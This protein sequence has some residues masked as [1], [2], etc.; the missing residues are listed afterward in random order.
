VFRRWFGP[1]SSK[2]EK[3]LLQRCFGDTG[4]VERLI[5]YEMARRPQLSR[6]GASK[7]ALDRWARDR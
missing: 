6:D 5:A 1:R 7:A 2:A 4:Q 3:Q